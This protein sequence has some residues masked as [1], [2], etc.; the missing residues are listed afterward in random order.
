MEHKL[1]T[2]KEYYEE[3]VS[4]RKTFEIRKNDRNFQ[5][6][7]ILILEEVEFIKGETIPTG[8]SVKVEVTYILNDGVFGLDSQYCIMSI[9]QI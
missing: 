1:K 2:Y 3:V 6:A 4:G 7:D 9:K 8:N 5:V